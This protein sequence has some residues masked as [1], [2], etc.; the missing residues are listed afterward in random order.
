MSQETKKILIIE[1]EFPM[2]YLIEYQLKHNGYEVNLAKDG[3][4]GLKEIQKNRPDLVLLDVMMPGMDGFEVCQRIKQ[5]PETS[6]IPVIFV[7]ASEA[8]EYRLRAFDVG[9]A[10]YVTKPFRPEQLVEQIT[11]VLYRQAANEQPETEPEANVPTAVTPGYVTSFFSPKGG[12]G[13]TTLAIQYAEAV[14]LRTGKTAVLIDL[15]L[16]LGGVAPMLHLF[17]QHDI[18]EL[19]NIPHEYISISTIDQFVLRYQEK[20]FVIPAPGRLINLNVTPNLT[21]FR[22][23]LETL[24]QAGYEVV[25]DVGS[26]INPYTV[27]VMSLSELVFVVTSGDP[28]TDQLVNTFCQTAD[29]LGLKQRRLMPV[30]NELLGPVQEIS[31][32]HL[33]V[34]RIPFTKAPSDTQLWLKEQGLRKM[35]ALLY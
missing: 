35:V 33:P 23:V 22:H 30:I 11:A 6:D 16:P 4:T 10:A 18:I 8:Y 12:V 28:L 27:E 20:L 25:I 3:L 26:A 7:T 13:L 31:L 29:Q 1:D 5:A 9:A 21:V 17:P 14:T 32:T 2:R 19:L 24:T 34:A 15:H